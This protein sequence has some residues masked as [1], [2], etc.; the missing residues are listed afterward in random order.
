MARSSWRWCVVTFTVALAS[1]VIQASAAGAA[2]WTLGSPAI[3]TVPATT[4]LN[5]VSCANSGRCLAVG[6]SLAMSSH[7]NEWTFTPAP[8][9]PSGADSIALNAVSCVSASSCYAVGSATTGDTTSVLVEHW[10]GSSWSSDPITGPAGAAHAELDGISC[11]TARVC[12]AVGY[13]QAT[14][15]GPRLALI[16]GRS[17]SGWRLQTASPA[18]AQVRWPG[19]RAVRRTRA[20]PSDLSRAGRSRSAG[21]G[22][23]GQ[24]S[25]RLR[26][27]TEKAIRRSAHSTGS[28][29]CRRARAGP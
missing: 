27:T 17:A 25:P 19:S 18:A 7:G 8:V 9:T 6:G 16:E 22:P 12:E 28:R 23:R 11:T 4:Q 14:S 21:M 1:A 3:P 24:R 2:V 10:D 29:V 20:P 13:D 26:S 5:G 15:S